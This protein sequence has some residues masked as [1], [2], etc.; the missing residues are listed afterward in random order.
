MGAAVLQCVYSSSL[1]LLGIYIL[2]ATDRWPL[3]F[4]LTYIREHVPH[5]LYHSQPRA[6]STEGIEQLGVCC[7][8]QPSIVLSPFLIFYSV[9]PIVRSSA[10]NMLACDVCQILRR[11]LLATDPPTR[12]F[13]HPTN[14]ALPAKT[15]RTTPSGPAR[16]RRQSGRARYRPSRGHR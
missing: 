13:T 3:Y 1:W 2:S 10:Q 11:T 5:R 12:P 8:A 16:H 15:T 6:S 7:R 4:L 9:S 14:Q